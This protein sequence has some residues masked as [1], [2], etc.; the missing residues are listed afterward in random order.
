M[1]CSSRLEL[2]LTP[3]TAGIRSQNEASQISQ[4]FAAPRD[5][6]GF[7]GG[8]H[9]DVKNHQPVERNMDIELATDLSELDLA[10]TG[11]GTPGG[12]FM[13]RFWMAVCRSQDLPKGGTKPI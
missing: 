4:G 10:R 1:E 3:G 13:R 8:C 6:L 9:M 2:N 12:R 5:A 7:S 11:P